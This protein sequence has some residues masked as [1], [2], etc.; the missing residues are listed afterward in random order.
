VDIPPFV[1]ER[2]IPW[3]DADPA[4]TL[5][6]AHM[7]RYCLEAVEAWYVDRTTLDW[8]RLNA[9]RGM[10]APCVRMELDFIAPALVGHIAKLQVS[11]ESIGR[12]SV[13]FRV[14]SRDGQGGH[15]LW[16]GVFKFVFVD[17]KAQRAVPVPEDIR[18]AL[19]RESAA[20]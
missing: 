4:G 7:S 1:F 13:T 11:V 5:Y 19:Q 15:E 16:K 9:E 2:R 17:A 3:G 6:L 20:V 14:D 18:A 8:Q 12:S 10:G